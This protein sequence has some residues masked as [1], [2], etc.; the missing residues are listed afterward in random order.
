MFA[1]SSRTSFTY[2]TVWV[3]D[4][5]CP[6]L[7]STFKICLCVYS[8]ESNQY[9]RK[10]R[11]TLISVVLLVGWNF[12]VSIL[13]STNRL[14]RDLHATYYIKNHLYRRQWELSGVAPSTSIEHPGNCTRN[15][16]HLM[17][18]CL[19]KTKA[20]SIQYA[21]SIHIFITGL[22]CSLNTLSRKLE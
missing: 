5:S 9:L 8:P 16:A 11:Q 21:L 12:R 7:S 6:A 10:I 22:S 15:L 19:K 20:I 14:F 18:G 2:L 13:S 3:P 4:M 17:V 1:C